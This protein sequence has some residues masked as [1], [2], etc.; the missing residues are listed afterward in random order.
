MAATAEERI[1]VL[2]S[3]EDIFSL[4]VPFVA[5]SENRIGANAPEGKKPHQGI[6]PRNR[7][8]AVGATSAKWPET[9]QVSGQS[10]SETVLG[11]VIDANGN[12]LSD[13]SGKT[14]TWDFENQLTQAVVP[15]TGTVTFKYDPFGRRIQ[16]SGPLGTTNYV[17]DVLN[18]VEEVDNGG[19]LLADYTHGTVIDETLSMLR[20]GTA[21]YDL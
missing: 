16:E 4:A 19:T 11:I 8:I 2:K 18:V 9:H 21:S 12:T 7:T 14:Y 5:C 1:P 13:P 3:S 6:F 20:G 10:W 17:Y 15:G